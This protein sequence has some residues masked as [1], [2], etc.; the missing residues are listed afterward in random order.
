M[1]ID[2]VELIRE[3]ESQ[4][5]KELMICFQAVQIRKLKEQLPDETAEE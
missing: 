5:P 3:M 4:F 2:P 1:E